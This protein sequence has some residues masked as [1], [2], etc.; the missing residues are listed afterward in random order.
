MIGCEKAAISLDFVMSKDRDLTHNAD[1]HRLKGQIDLLEHRIKE[2]IEE[3]DAERRLVAEMREH[4]EKAG[5]QL[6]GLISN[7]EDWVDA[8]GMLSITHKMRSPPSPAS[9][10]IRESCESLVVAC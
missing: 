8:L 10:Q 9:W 4:V 3:R 1:V 6:D 5:N 7:Q 2:L